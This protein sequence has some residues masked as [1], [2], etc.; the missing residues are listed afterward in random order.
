MKREYPSTPAEAFEASIE[1]AY[2]AEQLAKAE[3]QGRI[4]PF[5]AVPELPV[6]TA[7]DIGVGD[8]TAIWFWQKLKDKIY[9]VGYY[10]NSGEG[11]PYYIDVLEQYRRRLGWTYGQHIVPHD[12]KV[13]EFGTGRT[14]VEQML[15]HGIKPTV[16]AAA[17][18]EDGINSVRA[19]LPHCWFAEDECS[20][21]IRHVK[22]YRKDWDE[23]RGCW[24]D[25]PRHDS[26]SHAADALRYLSLAWR[27][28]SPDPVAEPTTKEIIR[29]MC[30]PRT[31]ADMWKQYADELRERDDAELPENFEEFNLNK[32]STME[33]K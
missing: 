28:I 22:A 17:S 27:E 26:S 31:Y 32:P 23:T 25:K 30:K 6:N 5:K 4:G 12:A 21:G 13:R 10:E 2:Y 20:T 9:L 15:S 7:W 1:G 14:R 11:L 33:T 24:K 8:A 16:C 3:L 29:D 18:L 19:T